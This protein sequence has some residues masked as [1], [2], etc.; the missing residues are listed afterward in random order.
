MYCILLLIRT[1]VST[2]D[3]YISFTINTDVQVR[4]FL[5]ITGKDELLTD[6]RFTTV[7]NRAKFVS[8]W[9]EVRGASLDNKTTEHWLQNFREADLPAMPCHTLQTLPEDPHLKAVGLMHFENHPTEGKTVAIRSTINVDGD[10]SPVRSTAAPRGW[11]TYD[12]LG[13][14]GFSGTEIESLLS[15]KAAYSYEK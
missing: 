14:L 9:F 15:Q 10:Y 8:E 5:K 2:K 12:I 4:A 11:D 1:T 13:N 7:A 6:T 3:G